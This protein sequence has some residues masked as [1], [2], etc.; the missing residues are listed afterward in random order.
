MDFQELTKSSLLVVLED[1]FVWNKKK[2]MT[3]MEINMFL[4]S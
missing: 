2:M 4:T 3:N 1:F